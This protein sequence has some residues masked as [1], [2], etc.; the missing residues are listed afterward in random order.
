MQADGAA[1]FAATGEAYDLFMG[2]YS[3]PAPVR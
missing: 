1:S 2:R 3:K